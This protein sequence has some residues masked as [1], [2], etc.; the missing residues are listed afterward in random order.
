MQ[1]FLVV[2]IG[3]G[4]YGAGLVL[5]DKVERQSWSEAL[6]YL[7]SGFI[8]MIPGFAAGYIVGAIGDES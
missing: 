3:A 1:K 8:V 7:L 6:Y 4:V 2:L 5:F